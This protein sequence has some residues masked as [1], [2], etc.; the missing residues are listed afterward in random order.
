MNSLYRE[1]APVPAAAW[2][3]IEAEASQALKRTLAARKLVDFSGPLGWHT[4]SVDPGRT[5]MLENAPYPGVETRMRKVQP[6]VETRVAF[7]LARS[8]I[9]AIDRGAT[10]ADLQPVIDAAQIAALAEDTAVFYGYR[11]GGVSGICEAAAARTLSLTEDYTRYPDTV[12]E[13]VNRLRMASVDGPYAI[14]LGPRCYTGLT[15]TRDA[16]YPVIEHVRRLLEGPV[17][18]APAADGALIVSLRGGDF[19]L[20]VGQDFSIGYLDHTATT[21]RLYLQESFTFRVNAPE[22]AIPLRYEE[23]GKQ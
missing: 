10:D 4:S 22:A 14:A 3:Q 17:V 23:A 20:S 18:W 15:Q 8:E 19:Q 11:D 21:I 2:E 9:D 5:E 13:A 16:G 6:L 7:E 12:A 1:L